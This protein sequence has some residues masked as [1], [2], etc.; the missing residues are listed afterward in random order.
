MLVNNYFFFFQ[1]IF[2]NKIKWEKN[3]YSLSHKCQLEDFTMWAQTQ[4]SK[5]IFLRFTGC[6]QKAS[7]L[8]SSCPK[9]FSFS[10]LFCF[11]FFFSL[12]N[13]VEINWS[14]LNDFLWWKMFVTHKLK[15]KRK[16]EEHE[17]FEDL[18]LSDVILNSKF[19]LLTIIAV[20][21]YQR[22]QDLF[23]YTIIWHKLYD[24]NGE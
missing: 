18:T 19:F 10:I 8:H 6:A 13:L 1:I 24:K 15:K 20:I 4:H 14:F 5:H 17:N 2:I 22:L 16:I 11:F 7:L 23:N 21:Q 12:I 3:Y 9:F